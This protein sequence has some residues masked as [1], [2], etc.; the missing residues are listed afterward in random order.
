MERIKEM[1]S[2]EQKQKIAAGV[3][4]LLLDIGHPEMPSTKPE[5]FL[6]VEGFCPLSW[7]EI[8]PNW[9]YGSDNP[10]SIN[11]Y[12]EAMVKNCMPRIE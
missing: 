4:K 1:F 5:F 7:A 12:N 8:Q 9:M 6:R 11:P 10:S 3:E 2:K